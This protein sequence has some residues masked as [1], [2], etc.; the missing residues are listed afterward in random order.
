LTDEKLE[1]EKDQIRHLNGLELIEYIKSAIEVLVSLKEEEERSQEK[2]S[3]V[4][5]SSFE[6]IS[7][8]LR[9]LSKKCKKGNVLTTSQHTRE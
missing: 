8:Q 2:S 5:Q 6:D 1:S 3:K 4:N 7:M 9:M